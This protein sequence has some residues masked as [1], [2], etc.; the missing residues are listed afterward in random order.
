NTP[1]AAKGIMDI[2]QRIGPLGEVGGFASGSIA[3]LG[4]T[5][6]G[7][8]VAE[9]IAA[10]GIKNM[11]LA[12]VAGESATKGQRAAYKDLGLDAGQ[13]AKDMQTDAEATTLKVIKSI[14]KLD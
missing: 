5:I 13:V 9:E 10:T 1:A 14:S 3:A 7:M 4:A 2:V 6:R 8:G 11:M 12:L